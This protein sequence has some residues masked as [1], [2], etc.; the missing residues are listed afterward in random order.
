MQRASIRFVHFVLNQLRLCYMSL[1]DMALLKANDETAPRRAATALAPH[2]REVITLFVRLSRLLGQPRSFGEIY[3]LLFIS[4][5]PLAMDDLMARLDLS[6][7]SASQGLKFLR[8]L[9]AV[10]TI[11]VPGNRRVHYEAV[12]EL[13]GLAGRFLR[14]KIEPHLGQG[15]ERLERLSEMLAG[16]PEEHREHANRRVTMLRSWSRNSRRVLPLVV[17]VLGE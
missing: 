3:G 7:G 16:L 17:R 11:E 6:K 14:E 9:G 15:E 12:A 13:R 2:E 10:R 4:P 8:N 5:Q 1:P